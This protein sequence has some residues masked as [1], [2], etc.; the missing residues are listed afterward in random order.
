[1]K[2]EQ[3]I[4]LLNNLWTINFLTNIII[5]FWGIWTWFNPVALKL[6]IILAITWIMLT[7]VLYVA[8]NKL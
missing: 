5:L 4:K 7:Y 6:L 3:N 1:M 8:E 2:N